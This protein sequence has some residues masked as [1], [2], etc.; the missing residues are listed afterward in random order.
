[1]SAAFKPSG[2]KTLFVT[3]PFIPQILGEPALVAVTIDGT[4]AVDSLFSYQVILKT[5][6]SLRHLISDTAN[7]NTAAWLGREMSVQIQLEGNGTVVAGQTGDSGL[8]N[9]GAGVREING[10]VEAARFLKTEE[11]HAYYEVSLKPWLFAATL[12]TDCRIYQDQT[13]PEIIN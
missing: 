7:F 13:A 5:P 6:A 4:E 10:V 8:G 1:M 2:S 12:V 11:R 9:I 3:S